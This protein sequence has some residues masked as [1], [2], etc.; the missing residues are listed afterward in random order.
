MNNQVRAVA[1][2]DLAGIR[3]A[4]DMSQIGAEQLGRV[5]AK[6]RR[7]GVYKAISMKGELYTIKRSI[8]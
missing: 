7:S 1:F 3:V 8:F 6:E 4:N 2:D 5:T